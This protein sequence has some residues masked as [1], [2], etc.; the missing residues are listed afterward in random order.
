MT[1]MDVT[2]LILQKFAESETLHLLGFHE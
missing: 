2:H 1:T